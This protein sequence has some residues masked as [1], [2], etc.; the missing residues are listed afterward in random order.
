[1]NAIECSKNAQEVFIL[2]ESFSRIKELIDSES[3]TIDEIAN[4]ITLDPTLSVTIL[5]LA[6][7]S[8]FNYPGQI[9]TISKAVLVLGITEVYN[10]V[11]AYFIKDA[12]KAITSDPDYIESFWEQSVDCALIIKFLG[13]ELKVENS[14]RLFLLGLLHNL[15]EL[16][17]NQSLPNKIEACNTYTSAE[18]PWE[19]QQGVINFTYGQCS[20]LLLKHW[21]LPHSLIEPISQQDEYNLDRATIDAKL[22]YL[23]KRTMLLNY[24][25][26]R[27]KPSSLI[28]TDM[29]SD[30]N[31]TPKM[32]V[33]ANHF[34]NADRLNILSILSPSAATIY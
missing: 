2:S 6:N 20:A 25:C 12:F 7:S 1:M 28:S 31:V 15:G 14:E 9:E 24:G 34:C 29:L 10:L 8:F 27:H 32:I 21:Q 11:I 5:K 26:K 16:A 22:L 30:L 18:F 19:K 33:A 13:A 4:I 3:S 17:V 23:A